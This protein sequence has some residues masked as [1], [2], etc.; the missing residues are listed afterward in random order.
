MANDRSVERRLA[1]HEVSTVP[2]LA[3]RRDITA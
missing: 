1:F 3:R 2:Y